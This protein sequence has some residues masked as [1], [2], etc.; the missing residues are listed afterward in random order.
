ML[1]LTGLSA[2]RCGGPG[3]GRRAAASTTRSSI[4]LVAGS[5]GVPYFLEEQAR[6]AQEAPDEAAG[7]PLE[8]S[9]FLAAR[10]DELGPEL[11]RL[12]G[13]IAVAGEGVQLDVLA[14]LTEVPAEELDRASRRALPAG[15]SSCARADRPGTSSASATR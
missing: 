7:A 10:L 2:E 8:L 15:G 14:R 12:L 1:E 11:K 6:A 13:E 3:A 9:V 4:G 5:D